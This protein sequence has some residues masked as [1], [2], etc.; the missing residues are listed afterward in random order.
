MRLG[1]YTRV[2]TQP[3]ASPSTPPENLYGTTYYG[4]TAFNGSVYKLSPAGSETV[5][6]NFTGGADGANPAAGVILDSAGNLYGTTTHGGTTNKGIVFK[7]DTAG[8]ET[9]LH[10]F[11]GGTDGAY[12]EGGVVF[13]SAGNLYGTTTSGVEFKLNTTGNFAVQ[14]TFTGSAGGYDLESGVVLG[15]AGNICG[16]TYQAG[17]GNCLQ[18]DGC[19]L[20]Y[21]LSPSGQETTLYTFTGG[22]DGG[23]PVAGLI[24]DSAGNLYGTAQ[25]GGEAGL[26]VVFK[27][28]P[29]GN[30]TVLHSFLGPPDGNE[31]CAAVTMDSAGNL[32]G[33]TYKG[34]KGTEGIV[35]KLTPQ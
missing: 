12:P 23:S 29:L 5:L 28:D 22:G 1:W 35:F 10:T 34:G 2:P 8:N 14:Y 18:H 16:I 11:T 31:P 17:G 7:L 33:T 13:D 25:T 24:L 32:Y 4:G 6:H 30:E 20:V 19:G 3:R 9:I 21:K 27:V 26:G 15:S